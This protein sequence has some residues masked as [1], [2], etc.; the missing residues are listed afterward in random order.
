[1]SA[2]D[3]EK[4]YKSYLDSRMSGKTD[5]YGN[6]ISQGGGDNQNQGIELAK[7]ATGT[8]TVTGPAE[9][10]KTATNTITT[11]DA[12][13]KSADAILVATKRKS[14]QSTIKT[15]PTGL[16]DDYNLSKKKLLG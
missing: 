5:A 11:K 2:A 16:T 13:K 1:M 15:S 4:Q 8:A 14:R 9:I 7:S 3:Q 6:T 12:K 10:Q